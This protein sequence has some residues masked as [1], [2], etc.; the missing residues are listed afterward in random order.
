MPSIFEHYPDK[1]GMIVKRVSV[2]VG[3]EELMEGLTKAVLLQK[4]KDLY[5]FAS[6]YF[7]RLIVLRQ[8]TSNQKT[9][10]V[11]TVQSVSK[12][13]MPQG[14]KTLPA[15]PSRH[16]AQQLSAAQRSGCRPPRPPEQKQKK[17]PAPKDQRQRSISHPV[18]SSSSDSEKT[19]KQARIRPDKK[20]IPFSKRSST[21]AP[22]AP[23]QILDSD[24][25][26]SSTN[27]PKLNPKD[28]SRKTP[29]KQEAT[30]KD[31]VSQAAEDTAG[32]KQN[33]DL[34][35]LKPESVTTK[36]SLAE[37]R[38][39]PRETNEAASSSVEAPI[40]NTTA[41]KGNNE[42]SSVN[43]DEA[44]A[45]AFSEYSAKSRE[46]NDS[47]D[48][49][50]DAV[51]ATAAPK[52][53]N[54]KSDLESEPT[55]SSEVAAKQT[56]TFGK[57]FV[58]FR[59]KNKA[60]DL[61][62]ESTDANS[63]PKNKPTSKQDN[64]EQNLISRRTATLE[65]SAIEDASTSKEY[66]GE[67]RL[68]QEPRDKVE[69][70]GLKQK[71]TITTADV[72]EFNVNNNLSDLK[73]ESIVIEHS[74]FEDIATT[75]A[76]NRETSSKSDAVV[77][78]EDSLK[79]QKGN[80]AL[81][82]KQASIVDF[83]E[84]SAPVED[85]A[86]S[87]EENEAPNFKPEEATIKN[88]IESREQSLLTADKDNEALDLQKERDALANNN[89]P[90]ADSFP[91]D[92]KKIPENSNKEA[93]QFPPSTS[94]QSND[95]PDKRMLVRH[96]SAA[97]LLLEES[98][99]RCIQHESAKVDN[100][101][102]EGHRVA[103]KETFVDMQMKQTSGSDD[104]LIVTVSEDSSEFVKEKPNEAVKSNVPEPTTFFRSSEELVAEEDKEMNSTT[105]DTSTK[106]LIGAFNQEE[107]TEQT[108]ESLRVATA[109]S[110]E[111]RDEKTTNTKALLN[112]FLNYE[113]QHVFKPPISSKIED[114]EATGQQTLEQDWKSSSSS[115]DVQDH[116]LLRQESLMA[117]NSVKE[118]LD[119]DANRTLMGIKISQSGS[120]D[121]E[122]YS[123]LKL[124][125]ADGEE[126]DGGA[127]MRT[128]RRKRGATS[129]DMVKDAEGDDGTTTSN[130]EAIE[131]DTRP[132]EKV[133]VQIGKANSTS[134]LE[135][136]QNREDSLMLKKRP[137]IGDIDQVASVIEVVKHIYG[138][139]AVNEAKSATV[140]QYLTT[141][142]ENEQK[143]VFLPKTIGKS[144]ANEKRKSNRERPLSQTIVLNERNASSQFRRTKSVGLIKTRELETRSKIPTSARRSA[145][146]RPL[147][148]QLEANSKEL[149][150]NLN[151]KRS[152]SKED[153]SKTLE[154]VDNA[155]IATTIF[156]GAEGEPSKQDGSMTDTLVEDTS[157]NVLAVKQLLDQLA[158]VDT[159]TINEDKPN[160]SSAFECQ[161]E[162]NE[163]IIIPRSLTTIA[164]AKGVEKRD[165]SGQPLNESSKET[166]ES[167]FQSHVETEG[168]KGVTEDQS[169][170]TSK[171][172]NGAVEKSENFGVKNIEESQSVLKHQSE[173][174]SKMALAEDVMKEQRDNDKRR[175]NRPKSV[176]R[177]ENADS[178]VDES[179]EEKEAIVEAIEASNQSSE[180]VSNCPGKDEAKKGHLV[181]NKNDNKISESL[182][183]NLEKSKAVLHE[184]IEE[185]GERN[186]KHCMEA[187]EGVLLEVNQGQTALNGQYEDKRQEE[188]SDISE[189]VLYCEETAEATDKESSLE[190]K[191]EKS[192]AEASKEH[193]GEPT[194]GSIDFVV[195]KDSEETKNTSKEEANPESK[196]QLQ[197][198]ESTDQSGVTSNNEEKDTEPIKSASKRENVSRTGDI[199]KLEVGEKLKITEFN[200]EGRT[201]ILDSHLNVEGKHAGTIKCSSGEEEE[202]NLEGK[203]EEAHPS[204]KFETA[205][206][207][208]QNDGAP[209]KEDKTTDLDPGVNAKEEKLAE[210]IQSAPKGEEEADLDEKLKTEESKKQTDHSPKGLRGEVLEDQV[211]AEEEFAERSV[212]ASEHKNTEL[213]KDTLITD[214]AILGTE[215]AT[216]QVN[217]LKPEYLA[218]PITSHG[219]G[220]EGN[221]EIPNKSSEAKIEKNED[222][223]AMN[224]L[225]KNR[226][227][228]VNDI[229][230]Q[231]LTNPS[232]EE[233]ATKIVVQT[234]ERENDDRSV[235]VKEEM[236]NGQETDE[237]CATIS[238]GNT[239][240]KIEGAQNEEAKHQQSE[241]NHASISEIDIDD[242]AGKEARLK[243]ILEGNGVGS[244]P[245]NDDVKAAITIQ[246]AWKGFIT[247]KILNQS[248][249]QR[250]ENR[251]AAKIQPVF[252]G[253]VDR[254]K[255]EK[256]KPIQAVK[257]Y[258]DDPGVEDPAMD[259]NVARANK[260]VEGKKAIIEGENASRPAE[261]DLDIQI[262]NSVAEKPDF[263]RSNTVVE[264]QVIKS[265]IP[266]LSDDKV[267]DTKPERISLERDPNNNSQ[268]KAELERDVK[269]A[270]E[271]ILSQLVDE[272]T[273]G[274]PGKCQC[275][276]H[277]QQLDDLSSVES[278]DSVVTVVLKPKDET[279]VNREQN[280]E[281][282][283][284][285]LST[286][287]LEDRVEFIDH[288][289]NSLLDQLSG[290]RVDSFQIDHLERELHDVAT[291]YTS[292]DDNPNSPEPME[293][294]Y[295]FDGLAGS[296]HTSTVFAPEEDN[297]YETR[298]VR[299]PL[300]ELPD[301]EEEAETK[302]DEA[303][304]E[305][306]NQ[307]VQDAD[308]MA[309]T[310]KEE[311]TEG[312]QHTSELHDS[313]LVAVKLNASEEQPSKD[314]KLIEENE[315]L[316]HTSEFHD[317]VVVPLPSGADM[318][319]TN[320]SKQLLLEGP[321]RIHTVDSGNQTVQ[322]APAGVEAVT[323]RRPEAQ[324][325][326]RDTAPGQLR[327]ASNQSQ[328]SRF[329]SGEME[330]G[331]ANKR[332]NNAINNNNCNEKNMETQAATKIQ[333]GFRGYQ[334]R[335]QIKA[336][337]AAVDQKRQLR[338]R[339]SKENM[340][341]SDLEE[342]SAVKIQA[343][344][345]GFLVR[346]RQKKVNSSASA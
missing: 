130:G 81:A 337:N 282:P 163:D 87:K 329:A 165:E 230:Q 283:S 209:N 295:E 294:F 220:A 58:K 10:P 313:V 259:K 182:S 55:A 227:Q 95:D 91:Q 202:E 119:L 176:V 7:S 240:R 52:E 315:G 14:K 37:E 338:K 241:N 161:Q 63:P 191:I 42:T 73:Q 71:S 21:R 289:Q 168:D 53:D 94:E 147:V 84:D 126:S 16:V 325:S 205:D 172:R 27:L 90:S 75:K 125:I 262:E 178:G 265:T 267:E 330:S 215:I 41:S 3:L 101:F 136:Q 46:A 183:D 251:T 23:T 132:V 116:V 106:A 173:D 175:T 297:V 47:D 194:K 222:N 198:K 272:K 321:N 298:G 309:S 221:L 263:Y 195:L 211:Q 327:A 140:S 33:E 238:A 96:H 189:D 177:L 331:Q 318:K 346:R 299:T 245:R 249:I 300:R 128:E 303:K 143:H 148:R 69:D 142:L 203:T 197:P 186:S 308:L 285:A 166:S 9:Y 229:S 208:K 36:H 59:E 320:D 296:S 255:F 127:T 28:K 141:F 131:E 185:V 235:E 231:E 2:P 40:E 334:V 302:E 271:G 108:K 146:R 43:S 117:F 79:L 169:E 217:E 121:T 174:N 310:F 74:A 179:K 239:S 281:L 237:D 314:L 114:L 6:E 44:V 26:A 82:F 242:N 253:F 145:V 102:K 107:Q 224:D 258:L 18:R 154:S 343:G 20:V 118:L 207:T 8:Q 135:N 216:E 274:L 342:K 192:S 234:E 167:V 204:V 305:S 293:Y 171:E 67:S 60:L 290:K 12:V 24:V 133:G 188:N 344:V 226:S 22:K 104:I 93:L 134:L 201:T 49:K 80:E 311:R 268:E 307:S 150:E 77:K 187:G 184:N 57:D 273:Y 149:E 110:N 34:G 138:S 15:R 277:D 324:A 246:A 280:K 129:E 225:H 72:A 219:K 98:N 30:V 45:T 144:S 62:Q 65:D 5:V 279:K 32:L 109:L 304:R 278:A 341:D 250:D 13:N 233:I 333:A 105:S 210:R 248:K 218:K 247:R 232:G 339:S 213:I 112:S 61:E 322:Q 228:V 158:S 287:S 137:K 103:T 301:I 86:I 122:N 99:E 236:L 100:I 345:R 31:Q 256:L 243:D 111:A 56:G 50:H 11:R 323:S 206:S 266:P 270:V 317:T 164:S 155:L 48:L 17:E 244:S 260:I 326:L 212:F 335:K 252:R 223:E 1:V 288:V 51:E 66:I 39:T 257:E 83:T 151:F 54:E 180:A 254:L 261:E 97:P 276:S 170:D 89:T 120:T 160:S 115:S 340:K 196:I 139:E 152:G 78:V 199:E 193:N 38:A 181:E 35:A 113:Q 190:C 156:Q 153:S 275:G 29:L 264:L 123:G 291:M 269:E 214:E 286:S 4:P 316:R 328:T 88:H 19:G 292:Q 159:P 124:I 306:S 319:I 312:L 25:L 70:A 68:K 64:G 92:A 336:K 200:K 162:A 76:G 85:I 332:R 157:T 284:R